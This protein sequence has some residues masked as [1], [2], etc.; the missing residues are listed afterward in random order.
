MTY[1]LN[2]TKFIREKHMANKQR[3]ADAKRAFANKSKLDKIFEKGDI[4]FLK[5]LEI[6]EAGAGNSLKARFTGPFE[7]SAI[8]ENTNTCSLRNIAND[9][10]RR[11]HLGH[12]KKYQGNILN[13]H[14]YIKDYINIDT[15]NN[16][17]T[18]QSHLL[19]D[20]ANVNEARRSA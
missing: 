6:G 3:S 19:A 7:I 18:R 11:A 5:D 17:K 9:K 10:S 1:F 8:H 15:L 13:E 20:A 12:L 16:N 2:H 4:V 14:I